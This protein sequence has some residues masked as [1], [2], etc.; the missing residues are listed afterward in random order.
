MFYSCKNSKHNEDISKVVE[1]NI[2]TKPNI[3]VIVTDDAGY[4]D[5]VF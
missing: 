3:I 2:Q 1:T 5:F 4:V